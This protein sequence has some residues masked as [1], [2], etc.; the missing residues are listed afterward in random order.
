MELSN[1]K[2][3]TT[4]KRS[5]NLTMVLMV[6]ITLFFVW[7]ENNVG[8]LISGGLLVFSIIVVQFVNI[9]YVYYS[10][11]GSKVMIRYYPV[12]AF[13]G[14][15]YNSIEF[16]KSLLYFVKIKRYMAFSDLYLAVKTSKG[17]A[18]YPEV[19][20]VGLTKSEIQLIENDLN[21]LMKNR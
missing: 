3:T 10:S 15:E 19:S 4:I 14:K 21:S 17:I 1:K 12:I 2:R 7:I 6:L 5:F 18:E 9:N 20:L 13:F 11:E 8:A 16:D